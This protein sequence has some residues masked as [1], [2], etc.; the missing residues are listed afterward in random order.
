MFCSRSLRW[1]QYARSVALNLQT[2][3][4]EILVGRQLSLLRYAWKVITG[5]RKSYRCR[6]TTRIVFEK[7][8]CFPL[9]SAYWKLCDRAVFYHLLILECCQMLV[10]L[11]RQCDLQPAKL[12]QTIIPHHQRCDQSFSVFL[13]RDHKKTQACQG[14]IDFYLSASYPA[15]QS[16]LRIIWPFIYFFCD[17]YSNMVL[18]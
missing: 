16:D 13:V 3:P 2:L 5:L 7:D 12:L 17:V 4:S 10:S 18:T 11:T 6:T 1:Y 15:D 14:W 9:P 8:L